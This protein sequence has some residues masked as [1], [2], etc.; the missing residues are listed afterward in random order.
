MDMPR[1]TNTPSRFVVLA[2]ALLILSS[3][4]S[5]QGQPQVSLSIRGGTYLGHHESVEL[6]VEASFPTANGSVVT[7]Y[8]NNE[9]LF[10]RPLNG[11]GQFTFANLWTE[12][13]MGEHQLQ[14][15][16][17]DDNGNVGY[18]Y[19]TVVRVVGTPYS[20]SG[21]PEASF[22]AMRNLVKNSFGS[23]P[24]NFGC[25]LVVSNSTAFQTGPMRV[26]LM[27]TSTFYYWTEDPNNPI[28]RFPDS[29]FTSGFLS[30]F[31]STNAPLDPSQSFT[32]SI[33]AS[34]GLNC[35]GFRSGDSGDTGYQYHVYAIL[36]EFLAGAWIPINYTKIVSSPQGQIF[37]PNGGAPRVDLG[38]APSGVITVTNLTLSSSEVVCEG[39]DLTATATAWF[40]NGG[41]Q[42]VH[43][44][45]TSSTFAVVS[46]NTL[47]ASCVAGDTDTALAATY[48]KGAGTASATKPVR[49]LECDA[50]CCTASLETKQAF[51][52]A[53]GG[54]GRVR[55][56]TTGG[57]LW[58][59]ASTN[60]WIRAEHSL[61][62]NG[63]KTVSYFVE[64]NFST[65]VRI[66][67]LV[68]ASRNLTIRQAGMESVSPELKVTT[69]A[70]QSLVCGQAR[71]EGTA[72]DKS[73]IHQVL[74]QVGD[75]VVVAEGTTDWSCWLS[76]DLLRPGINLAVV[77]AIDQSGNSSASRTNLLYNL[78]EAAVVLSKS[79]N[80][81]VSGIENGQCLEIDRAYFV[82]AKPGNGFA[83]S[84]W[85][86]SVTSTA[87]RLNFVMQS[88]LVLHAN[89]VDIQP[90]KAE[91]TSHASQALVA[92]GPIT[93]SGV[94]SDNAGVY[95]VWLHVNGAAPIPAFGNQSWSRVISVNTGTNLVRVVAVDQ[96][97][98]RSTNRLTLI[99]S[100]FV[101]R[102]GTYHGLFYP[103]D[104]VRLPE[105]GSLQITLNALGR[106]SGILNLV[107]AKNP[108]AG[109]F[110]N[111]G[112]ASIPLSKPGGGVVL[113]LVVDFTAGSESITGQ[114][115]HVSSGWASPL[116]AVRSAAYSPPPT[117]PFAPAHTWVL[118]FE[119]GAGQTM[120]PAIGSMQSKPA[121]LISFKGSLPDRTPLAY[122]ASVSRLG[123][124]PIH[125]SLR[126][127][128]GMLL[129]WLQLR[130]GSYPLASPTGELSWI[131]LARPGSAYFSMGL[132]NQSSVVGSTYRFSKTNS[133]LT[134]TNA[135]LIFDGG[136]LSRT[137]TNRITFTTGN[138]VKNQTEIQPLRF[139][140]DAESGWFKG[141]VSVN[142]GAQKKLIFQG[143]LLQKQ[144]AGEGFF[145]SQGRIGRV[146][147]RAANP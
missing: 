124:W 111:T 40:S 68:V 25:D 123:L 71:L 103:E 113:N 102:K 106:F 31:Q 48:R 90:P 69:P 72:A 45:W 88:N 145:S 41:K 54:E 144:N 44:A 112:H 86:G 26:R 62:H 19:S 36:E 115:A 46:R 121:S 70:I 136:G 30:G 118:P 133:V 27:S 39:G 5:A 116:F 37:P 125:L 96:A 47:Q 33:P 67:Y 139:T 82:N 114:V 17:S 12:P 51:F 23:G 129:G 61:D 143:T 1:L 55:V 105:S 89:F 147:L 15:I 63:S 132:T 131:Q 16:A 10:T 122:S 104:E 43:P 2:S 128:N 58:D 142:D 18:S 75:F 20:S 87:A 4:I 49:I 138:T 8:D 99:A 80:G 98:L 85:V 28:Q 101:E 140:I 84:N 109:T 34:L 100:P 29:G 77:R 127:S 74:V 59:V 92:T 11:V 134:L 32:V 24:I 76:S 107:G 117:V 130:S 119:P 146:Q 78:P 64:T 97:G 56:E 108:F 60:S 7:V 65:S 9:I 120:G 38:I 83:F 81:T 52:G 66:G 3:A 110:D 73:G 6:V 42:T 22:V 94:A 57:C 95:Q 137:V 50:Q 53:I 35:P 141:Q 135:L 126:G 93:V 13:S 79:G 21:F 91:F 14:A